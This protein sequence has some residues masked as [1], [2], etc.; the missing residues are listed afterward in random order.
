MKLFSVF[1][2]HG[3]REQMSHVHVWRE[4]VKNS[5]TVK[6]EQK[7]GAATATDTQRFKSGHNAQDFIVK[8]FIC[9]CASVCQR[10]CVCVMAATNVCSLDGGGNTVV[11][12]LFLF[13]S[14][15]VI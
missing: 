12:P 15:C 6:W 5:M 2:I 7:Q 11:I 1:Q 3:T 13:S 10:M 9:S 8:W 4:L 14:P